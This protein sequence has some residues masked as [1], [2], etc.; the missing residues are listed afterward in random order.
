MKGG[1][2]RGNMNDV[3][4]PL[5][6]GGGV[7]I[8]GFAAFT[9]EGGVIMNNAARMNGG[10]FHTGGRGSFKKTGGIV[11]GANAPAGYRNI[12]L[13]G[14]GTPKTYGHAV[15]VATY[16]PSSQYRNDTVKEN[17]NLS[18]IGGA[19]GSNLIGAGEKWDNPNKTPQGMLLAIFLPVLTAAVSAIQVFRER[20][21]KKLAI[22]Q[23]EA[24][25]M[26]ETVFENAD[27][28]DREKAIGKFLLTKLSI[29]QIAS[30]MQIAYTT[31]DYHAKNVYRKMEVQSRTELLV[32]LRRKR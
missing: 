15:C 8:A 5:A 32:K 26:P 3:L 31:V 18:F 21:L 11:Y 10:G 27:L 24:D 22:A 14:A 6:C 2:I 9:M 4:I 13:R 25:A 12:A 29:K 20:A 23:E 28:T 19:R 1:T 7:Y 17:D 16:Y 30:V